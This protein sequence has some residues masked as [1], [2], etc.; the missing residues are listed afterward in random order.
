[1]IAEIGREVMH[2]ISA[3]RRER[4]GQ[5]DRCDGFG[6][7][8]TTSPPRH[9]L[10]AATSFND[11]CK[12]TTTERAG[13]S[14]LGDKRGHRSFKPRQG[15][16][17]HHPRQGCFRLGQCLTDYDQRT[18][19][20]YPAAKSFRLTSNQDSINNCQD[21]V[22]IGLNCADICT[23]LDRGTNGKKLDDLSRSVREA[24]NQLTT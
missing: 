23:A 8:L 7:F 6:F 2:T 3:E 4:E 12:H 19:P 1:M 24:I 13:Q 11:G 17:E 10:A 14:S 18:F 15:D 20:S 5:N 16:L 21:Y 22:E 9:S